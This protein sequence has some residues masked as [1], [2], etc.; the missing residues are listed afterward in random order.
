MAWG[1]AV[2]LHPDIVEEKD[3]MSLGAHILF[4]HRNLEEW[5]VPSWK[6]D[7]ESQQMPDDLPAA[8][9]NQTFG[10]MLS[11]GA[12]SKMTRTGPMQLTSVRASNTQSLSIAGTAGR[13]AVA[14]TIGTRSSIDIAMLISCDAS[15]LPL[16][17]CSSLGTTMVW[18]ASSLSLQPPQRKPLVA[19]LTKR[20]GRTFGRTRI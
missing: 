6:I 20:Y 9:V 5:V 4:Y 1:G 17:V 16:M 19:M 14:C 13:Y 12:E 10:G 15:R 11:G 2:T 3:D 8:L 18:M 7:L